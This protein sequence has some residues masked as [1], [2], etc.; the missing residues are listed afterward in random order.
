M[1]AHVPTEFRAFVRSGVLVEEYRYAPG[2]APGVPVHT[3]DDYQLGLPETLPGLYRYRKS[4]VPVPPGCVSILHPGEPHCSLPRDP[5]TAHAV[6]RMLYI[7]RGLV[8]AIAAR[9]ACHATSPGSRSP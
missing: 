4:A 6:Y 1:K 8:A 3:H 7:P 5:H 2:P 9:R